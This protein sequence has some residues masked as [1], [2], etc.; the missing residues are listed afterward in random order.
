MS[1]I[2]DGLYIRWMNQRHVQESDLHIP[3][4]LQE[5]LSPKLEELRNLIQENN[6]E[7]KK[8][9]NEEKKL[10]KAIYKVMIKEGDYLRYSL[11]TKLVDLYCCN[12]YQLPK[13]FMNGL[14]DLKQVAE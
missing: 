2:A 1:N 3:Q 5:N 10:K 9:Q 7:E 8:K 11:V 4:R 6:L 12:N 14:I 13:N